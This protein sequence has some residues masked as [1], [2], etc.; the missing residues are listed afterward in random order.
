M[1]IPT[2]SSLMLPLLQMAGDGQPHRLSDAVAVIADYVGLTDAERA[3]TLPSGRQLKLNYRVQ[4][5]LRHLKKAGLL[6][7]IERGQFIISDA[8]RAVLKTNPLAI[9]R[10][11]LMQFPAYVEFATRDSR[12]RA[13][14]FEG[15][16]YT[17]S[18]QTPKELLYIIHSG[19]QKEL[20]DELLENILTASPTFFERVVI[21]LLA[22]MGY[23]KGKTLGRTGDGGVDGV[24]QEDKLG[25]D[26]IYVQAKRWARHQTVGRPVVQAF[27]GSLTGKG[28][29]RGVL[30]TTSRFSQEAVQY[31]RSMQNHNII[32]IDGRALTDLMIEHNVGVM[33]EAAYVVKAIDRDYFEQS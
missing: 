20:A 23:G 10:R 33:V 17:Q 8:G 28:A 1:T 22:S 5:A 3:E 21:D 32:L 11:F 2:Y 12:E 31:A 6:L 18:E 4:V 7:G 13:I 30:I 15:I 19:L 14:D 26:L 24:I 16:E 9:N 25:L 27:V 29:A